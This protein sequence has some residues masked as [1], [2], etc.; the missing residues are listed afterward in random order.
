MNLFVRVSLLQ[1]VILLRSLILLQE[2]ITLIAI[3]YEPILVFPFLFIIS[4][5]RSRLPHSVASHLCVYL[6]SENLLISRRIS[7]HELGNVCYLL[8]WRENL[9]DPSFF[10]KFWELQETNRVHQNPIYQHSFFILQQFVPLLQ[11]LN[12]PFLDL[13]HH[14]HQSLLYYLEFENSY[15]CYQF[16]NFIYSLF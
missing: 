3:F 5:N 16:F 6:C 9:C 14:L 8:F 13:H 10:H 11:F 2:L 7:I 12:H 1:I 4:L 15:Q